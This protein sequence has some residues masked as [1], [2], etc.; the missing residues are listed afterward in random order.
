MKLRTDFVSN[1]SSSSFIVKKEDDTPDIFKEDATILDFRGF[2]DRI[3]FR[4]VFEP[5]Q[6]AIYSWWYNDSYSM[7]GSENRFDIKNAIETVSDE[8]FI[9]DFVENRYEHFILPECCADYVTEICD[10]IMATRRIDSEHTPALYENGKQSKDLML[11]WQ[12]DKDR[13][14]N[15]ERDR[16]REIYS[17]MHG[18]IAEL[19]KP[20]MG[21]WEFYMT[22]LGDECG[23]EQEGRQLIHSDCVRWYWTFCNH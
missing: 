22:E 2:T 18:R 5:F 23:A 14:Y 15:A 19:L 21:D 12:N 13:R 17:E 20:V 11:K 8:K 1:S 9:E 16:L 10:R 7:A 4:A 3:L 6:N